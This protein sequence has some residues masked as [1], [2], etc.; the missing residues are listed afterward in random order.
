MSYPRDL[1]EIPDHELRAE[2]QRRQKVR[3][4][5]LCDY[6]QQPPTAAVCKVGAGRHQHF[7]T[8]TNH[9]RALAAAGG[10]R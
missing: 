5:G 8:I 4:R 7:D 6:C 2:L 10:E 3:A 1:D 9:A